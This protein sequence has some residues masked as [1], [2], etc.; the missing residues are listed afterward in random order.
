MNTFKVVQSLQS[1]NVD[2][3]LLE[4]T[5]LSSLVNKV[6]EDR[7]S[8]HAQIAIAK[9]IVRTFTRIGFTSFFAIND[10]V[11]L[12]SD[13][14]KFELPKVYAEHSSMPAGAGFIVRIGKGKLSSLEGYAL[15]GNWPDDEFKFCIQ[16]VSTSN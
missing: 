16:T 5:V 3:T 14:C 1:A 9:V 4:K 7:E 6:G 13:H 8:L 10:D 11:S 15:T 12:I 2:I